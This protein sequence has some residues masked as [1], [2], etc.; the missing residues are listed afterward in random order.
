MTGP[1]AGYAEGFR[2]EL[3]KQGYAPLSAVNQLRVVAHLSRWCLST[4]LEIHDLSEER[5]AEFLVARRAAGYTGWYTRAALEP[6]V[7]FLCPLGVLPAP[8]PQPVASAEEA[9]IN[10]YRVYLLAERG[11][12][13]AT[14]VHRT[15]LARVF[16]DQH[17]VASL[18]D[19]GAAE[20]SRFL[21][22]RAER[23]SAKAEVSDLR[24]LLRFLFLR[25]AT[26]NRLDGAV[27]G[28]A[29]W[30]LSGLPRGL[31]SIQTAALLD[32]CDRRRAKGRRDYA[33]LIL[34]IRL[35]LRAGEVAALTLDDIDWSRAEVVVR[36]KRDRNEA[37]PLPM[38]VG[39]ALASYLRRGRPACPHRG[40][41]IRAQAP[42]VPLSSAGIKQIVIA[43]GLRCGL[44]PIGAHRLRHSAATEMLRRGAHLADIAQVLRH[45]HLSTTAIYTKVDREALRS[46]ARPWPL[47]P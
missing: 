29:S 37:L 7:S 46:L 17:P 39:Q 2:A 12:G 47:Q 40:I 30:R 3:L 4:G 6:L 11:L 24:C 25:G 32:S 22:A 28:V 45:R 9:L 1:L 23:G 16:L 35:G 21:L 8:E 38:D 36:G 31:S 41:F 5:L 20:V 13:R 33:V 44:G 34:L 43:A 42:L 27:S 15:S 18:E 26:A 19:L 14:I 10:D